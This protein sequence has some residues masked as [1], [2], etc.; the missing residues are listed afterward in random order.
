M[1]LNKKVILKAI[2]WT[3]E[4]PDARGRHARSVLLAPYY[5]FH[6]KQL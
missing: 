5:Y 6:G 2:I 1:S 3:H 4:E